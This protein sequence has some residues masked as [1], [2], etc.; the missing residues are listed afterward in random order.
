MH[1]RL[2]VSLVL[3]PL[4]VLSAAASVA[5]QAP[6]DLS[7]TWRLNA[8]AS[9]AP[10]TGAGDSDSGF[11]GGF[12]IPARQPMGG[13]GAPGP[14][15]PPG[16]I[17]PEVRKQ[18]MELMRE[19]LE[20]IR[21]VTIAQDARSVSF[22]YEDGRTVRYRTDGKAEKHQAINGVVETETRW[23]KAKL[24]R[25]TNLD[26]GTTVEETF[27]VDSPR[28]LVIQLETSGGPGR[29]KPLRR[30]YDPVESLP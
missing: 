10:G 27:T 30:V 19:L 15:A 9:D 13:F 12:G 18:R 11:S 21:R 25:K 8:D 7:G 29:R 26:D 20:P 5:A 2:F 4:V 23:K 28:T 16:A 3:A 14:M 24:V 1:A 17:D 6:A 22:T